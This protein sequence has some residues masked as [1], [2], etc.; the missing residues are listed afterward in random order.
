MLGVHG[1]RSTTNNM[2]FPETIL[3]WILAALATPGQTATIEV[4]SLLIEPYL[5]RTS[6]DAN[7]TDPQHYDGFV[8]DILDHV[9]KMMNLDYTIHVLPGQKFG[10]VSSNGTWDGLIGEILYQKR[11][12][13]AAPLT[14]SSQRREAI[15][16]S[17]PF[18][19]FGPVIILRKPSSGQNSFQE[20]ISRLFLPLEQSVWMMSL[21]CYFGVSTIIYII[22][23]FNPYEWRQMA[24]DGEATHREAE[25]FNCNNSFW[26]TISSWMWQGYTRTPRSL[27]GR[28]VACF[29][30]I[31]VVFFLVTFTASLTN[32][33]RLGPNHQEVES[34][35]KI[36]GL[37]DLVKQS[38]VKY[39]MLKGGTTEQ[40]FRF[41]HVAYIQQIYRT[42][43][44]NDRLAASVEDAISKVRNSW[45]TA[46]A[47][48]MESTMAK[49]HVRQEPCDLYFVG[50]F[51]ISGS[52][53][54]GFNK[55]WTHADELDV[56]LL[57]MRENGTLQLLEDKW[58]AGACRSI[59]LNPSLEDWVKIPPFFSVDLGTFSGALIVLLFG[60]VA[61][62]LICIFEI[63]IYKKAEAP[64]NP[65][66]HIILQTQ[67]AAADHSAS[68]THQ[69]AATNV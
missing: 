68:S 17:I 30:W 28:L 48:I 51:S 41:A 36:R 4:A 39:G 1:I 45:K 58:F 2:K 52:Y 54:F 7:S 69:S 25:S 13:A 6:G 24:K 35:Y 61:G 16:F 66:A 59:M 55:A 33:L 63:V 10:S 31:Y 38:D 8:K 19:N 43:S 34:Y 57:Q 50:D 46:Y 47:F 56:T 29:W 26:F 37:Q 15:H 14:V 42:V 9:T 64:E 40:Y 11:H 22:A 23:R 27:G 53:G 21:I 5:M 3:V 49:Y 12:L 65:E 60:V 32:L 18:Q 20:R 44:K 62:G 67:D